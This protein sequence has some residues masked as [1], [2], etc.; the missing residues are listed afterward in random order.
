[1]R[2]LYL[3][4]L[5]CTLILILTASQVAAIDL[6]IGA[7][8]M[9]ALPVD[10]TARYAHDSTGFGATLSFPLGFSDAIKPSATLN[11]QDIS[12]FTQQDA[13]DSLIVIMLVGVTIAAGALSVGAA[14]N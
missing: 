9:G 14:S 12:H 8:N 2:P 11:G 10:T 4:V 1:M 3:R 5:T 6:K 7:M 13:K